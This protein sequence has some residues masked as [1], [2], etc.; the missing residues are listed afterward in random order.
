MGREP[1]G[2]KADEAYSYKK[3][4][5][6]ASGFRKHLGLES[7]ERLIGLDLYDNLPNTVVGGI[8]FKVECGVDHLDGVEAE[9]S[10]DAER[11]RYQVLLTPETYDLLESGN[12][13]GTWVIVHE[14][15]HVALHGRLLQR[16]AKMELSRKAAL[17]KGTPVPHPFYMDT[18]WQTD[19]FTAAA[20]MPAA[21]IA[22]FEEKPIKVC[23]Q[24]LSLV[25]CVTTTFGTSQEAAQYRIDTFKR[26]RGELLNA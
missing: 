15:A 2:I 25:R 26:R 10:Y 13:H 19:S 16:L 3:L 14:Y 24:A 22:H 23:G 8:P 6:M 4:E 12:P 17:Y 11:K 18:E 7:T 20:L 21:G 1:R 5:A 9:A